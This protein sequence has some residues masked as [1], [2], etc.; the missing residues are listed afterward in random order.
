[1]RRGYSDEEM[2]KVLGR[3]VL[4]VMREAERVSAVLQEGRAPSTA[5]IEALDGKL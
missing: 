5:T 1:M 3:N 4:R 2:T